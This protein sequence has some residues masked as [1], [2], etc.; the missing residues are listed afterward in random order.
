VSP[1]HRAYFTGRVRALADRRDVDRGVVAHGELVVSSR[2]GAVA[3]ATVDA[4]RDGMALVVDL[5]VEDRRSAALRPLLA[6][7]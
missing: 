1:R 2:N 7:A 3:L 6:P 5:G 4:T